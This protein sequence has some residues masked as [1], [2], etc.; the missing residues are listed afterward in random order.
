MKKFSSSL[1]SSQVMLI[2]YLQF[3][4]F[5]CLSLEKNVNFL[6]KICNKSIKSVL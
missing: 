2:Y 6:N 4:N 3:V 1:I 5:L